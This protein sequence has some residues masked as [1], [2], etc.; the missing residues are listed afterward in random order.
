[1][2]GIDGRGVTTATESC[3]LAHSSLLQRD[4]ACLTRPHA[5]HTVQAT[6]TTTFSLFVSLFE[7]FPK[8]SGHATV[9]NNRP[10]RLF[11]QNGRTKLLYVL[12]TQERSSLRDFGGTSTCSRD[13]VKKKINV[14]NKLLLRLLTA[15]DSVA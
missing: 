2:L 5:Q 8:I 14:T 6:R 1:M 12:K 13:E 10:D 11:S 15:T 4:P 3:Q 9:L 7:Q